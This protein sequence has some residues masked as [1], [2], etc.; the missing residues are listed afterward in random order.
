MRIKLSKCAFMLPKVEYLGHCITKKGLETNQ[1]K[2]RAIVNAPRPQNTTQLKSFL[3]MYGKFMPNLSTKLAPLN[4]LLRKGMKWHWGRDQRKSFADTKA[5]LTSSA[6]LAHYNPDKAIYLS[7]DASPYGVGAV[8]S[9]KLE[10][11]SSE[12]PIAFAS[13]SLSP[14]ERKYAQLDKEGLAIIFGVKRFHQYLAGR[15]FTIVSDH[16]PLLQ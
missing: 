14:A 15:K 10:D 6:V 7:C 16:Q 2:V 5:M 4:S 12:Q 1:E 11:T 3:G 13:R 8:L 9:H